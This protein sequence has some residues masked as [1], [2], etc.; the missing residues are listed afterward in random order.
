LKLY[1]PFKLFEIDKSTARVIT[2][3]SQL[4]LN[5]ERNISKDFIQKIISQ[6]GYIQ[7]DTISVTERSV[8]HILWSRAGGFNT[9]IVNGL[10]KEKKIFEYWSHAAAILPIKDFR[11]SL[12]FKKYYCEKYKKFKQENSR[13]LRN[14]LKRISEEGPLMSRDFNDKK[15]GES[16]WWNRKPSK[17]ALEFLFFSGELMVKERINFQKVYDLTERVLPFDTDVSFPTDEQYHKHLILSF[18]TANGVAAK[19]EMTYLRRYNKKSFD[20]HFAELIEDREITAIS[21]SGIPDRIYY[22]LPEN[23]EMNSQDKSEINL[24]SPFDNLI[25][26]RKRLKLLF[27]FDYQLEC[28]LPHQK[29]KFGYFSLPLIYRNKFIGRIDLKSDRKNKTLYINKFYPELNFKFSQRSVSDLNKKIKE[30]A[31]FTGCE[32][33]SGVFK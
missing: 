3:R 20:K 32:M 27:E 26:Q 1:Q 7:I 11:Y 24:L 16:G 4:L 2:L 8:N 22:V 21:V 12:I 5:T 25:I 15:T 10:F 29:R 19:D 30:Y 23:L 14:V 28:Y 31:V 6:L 13:L 33:V 9:N 18:L 17:E